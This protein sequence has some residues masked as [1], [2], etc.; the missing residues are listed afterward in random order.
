MKDEDQALVFTS[1]LG[2]MQILAHSLAQNNI[3][4]LTI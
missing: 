4:F 3:L 2:M 1:F